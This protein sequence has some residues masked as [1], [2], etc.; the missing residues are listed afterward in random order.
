MIHRD[1]IDPGKTVYQLA[2][3]IRVRPLA[4]PG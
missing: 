1:V 4:A 2:E 3:A